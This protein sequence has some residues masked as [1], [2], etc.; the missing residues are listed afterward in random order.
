MQHDL[1]STS[2]TCQL[3]QP[4]AAYL[5][6]VD[7]MEGRPEDTDDGEPLKWPVEPGTAIHLRTIRR[8]RHRGRETVF[9]L[10]GPGLLAALRDRP[11]TRNP[12]CPGTSAQSRRWTDA[13]L[14]DRWCGTMIHRGRGLSEHDEIVIAEMRARAAWLPGMSPSPLPAWLRA[15]ASYDRIPPVAAQILAFVLRAREMGRGWLDYSND[16]LAD[17]LDCHPRS[18]RRAIVWLEARALVWRHATVRPGLES[19]ERP[20][21][22]DRNLL[23]PGPRWM[24]EVDPWAQADEAGRDEL[25]TA[26]RARYRRRRAAR[27]RRVELA[28]VPAAE[29]TAAED[30]A[31]AECEEIVRDIE[32]VE[33]VDR[34]ETASTDAAAIV[35]GQMTPS[36][37]LDREAERAE[38]R[39]DLGAKVVQMRGRYSREVIER[40]RDRLSSNWEDTLSPRT[41]AGP[42]TPRDKESGSTSRPRRN[43]NRRPAAKTSPPETPPISIAA[44]I[45]DELGLVSRAPRGGDWYD[46]RYARESDRP[47]EP[48]HYADPGGGSPRENPDRDRLN[49]WA[50]SWSQSAAAEAPRDLRVEAERDSQNIDVP[51]PA[52]PELARLAAML[53]KGAR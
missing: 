14:V 5:A 12:R 26:G 41:L 20:V 19:S 50:E 24:R 25:A 13:E 32:W 39:A 11:L 18:I 7:A 53:L 36:E 9:H 49:K 4:S 52:D 31:R 2:P 3:V 16:D 8:Y 28:P 17:L 38:K 22:Q 15:R 34:R 23:V 46:R 21:D 6:H 33:D 42:T 37:A 44:A 35:A 1:N 47:P 29:W 43:R 48:C 51:M 10:A 45:A 30:E 40:T 27:A